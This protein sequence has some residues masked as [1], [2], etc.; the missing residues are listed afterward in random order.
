M[1][2]FIRYSPL[3]KRMRVVC[4]TVRSSVWNAFLSRSKELLQTRLATTLWQLVDLCWSN[5]CLTS[6]F[7]KLVWR[8]YDKRYKAFNFFARSYGSR[9][10]VRVIAGKQFTYIRSL[11]SLIKKFFVTE[12]EHQQTN[13][14]RTNGEQ[15]KNTIVEKNNAHS[16]FGL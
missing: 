12:V 10:D 8:I 11:M 3:R 13:K 6:T 4:P 7:I 16:L 1:R 14:R 9:E 15:T 2:G 5:S